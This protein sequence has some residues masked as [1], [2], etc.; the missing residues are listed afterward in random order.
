MDRKFIHWLLNEKHEGV[1]SDLANDVR[2]SPP[3]AGTSLKN[4]MRNSGACI[5]AMK[6]LKEARRVYR[7]CCVFRNDQGTIAS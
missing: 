4:H 2:S 6:A 1:I 7:G 3:P 5:E